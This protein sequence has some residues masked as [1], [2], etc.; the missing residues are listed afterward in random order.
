MEELAKLEEKRRTSGY[1]PEGVGI[2]ADG[3][4][5]WN[6]AGKSSGEMP[7][8]TNGKGG[9]IASNEMCTFLILIFFL[10]S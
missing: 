4:K 2:F 5:M 8:V 3:R 9:R 1:A 6:K 10:C 7:L